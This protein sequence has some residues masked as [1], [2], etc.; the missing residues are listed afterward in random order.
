MGLTMA[1][2]CVTEPGSQQ[3]RQDHSLEEETYLLTRKAYF[4]RT[5]NRRERTTP[6]P[7]SRAAP[8]HSI[9]EGSGL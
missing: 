9:V 6:A 2:K 1:S 8:N 5:L 7:I 3:H 4:R